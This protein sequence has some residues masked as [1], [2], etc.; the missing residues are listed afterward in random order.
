MAGDKEL[1]GLRYRIIGI[2]S[3]IFLSE[4]LYFLRPIIELL[5][6]SNESD[7]KIYS[8]ISTFYTQYVQL[9]YGLRRPIY[10]G[11]ARYIIDYDQVIN[12]FGMKS[13]IRFPDKSINT[14]IFLQ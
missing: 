8:D 3:L 1:Y 11:L 12:I 10:C 9:S 13:N 2:E 7:S 5:L 4:Q 14:S 6:P